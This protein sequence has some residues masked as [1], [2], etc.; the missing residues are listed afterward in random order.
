VIVIILPTGGTRIDASATA[1]ATERT[2]HKQERDTDED[3]D[4]LVVYHGF[5]T[6]VGEVGPPDFFFLSATSSPAWLG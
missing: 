2:D 1:A 5:F 6:Q 3:V 4:E